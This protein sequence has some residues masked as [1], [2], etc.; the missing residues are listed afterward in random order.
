MDKVVKTW[1]FHFCIYHFE[2]KFNKVFHSIIHRRKFPATELLEWPFFSV[3]WNLLFAIVI[4]PFLFILCRMSRIWSKI[5]SYELALL[6]STGTMCL[7]PLTK[8]QNFDINKDAHVVASQAVMRYLF[9]AKQYRSTCKLSE[10]QNLREYSVLKNWKQVNCS[11]KDFLFCWKVLPRFRPRLMS[12]LYISSRG[13]FIDY[14]YTVQILGKVKV[15]SL[16]WD[17]LTLFIASLI[18]VSLRSPSGEFYLT[19]HVNEKKTKNWGTALDQ[20]TTTSDLNLRLKNCLKI[21]KIF[22]WEDFFEKFVYSLLLWWASRLSL[23][24]VFCDFHC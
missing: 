22:D 17:Q 7:K 15:K 6:A 2:T 8:T 1:L 19:E 18:I 9:H 10:I 16:S 4:F 21:R 23:I 11:R 12:R 13:V 14:K 5:G 20:T 3:I 24:I